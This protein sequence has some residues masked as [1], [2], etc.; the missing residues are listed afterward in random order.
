MVAKEDKSF[1]IGVSVTFQGQTVKLRGWVSFVEMA[2]FF[3]AEKIG[4]NF[5]A[6]TAPPSCAKPLS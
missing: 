6:Q 3:E 1:S 2:S 4:R 5:Q